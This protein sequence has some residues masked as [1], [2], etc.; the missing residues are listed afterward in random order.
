MH[1]YNYAME[2][3][4]VRRPTV[5]EPGLAITFKG[6]NTINKFWDWIFFRFIPLL[7]KGD[8]KSNDILSVYQFRNETS[9]FHEL[10]S[11]IPNRTLLHG[12]VLL[13]PPRLRQVRVQKDHCE[14][15]PIFSKYMA[16]CYASY[17]WFSE[18]KS[19]YAGD[20]FVGLW[21]AG[22]MPVFGE[23][24]TYLGAGYIK[25][26]SYDNDENI[27]MAES[28]KYID[29]IDRGTRMVMLEFNM[30]HVNTYLFQSTRL[31]VEQ[32]P[33]GGLVPSYQLHTMRRDTFFGDS[34]QNV[35]IVFSFYF[36]VAIFTARD[37]L[38]VVRIGF[39]K[40]IGQ[41]DNLADFVCYLGCYIMLFINVVQVYYFRGILIAARSCDTFVNL[42]VV[43][44]ISIMYNNIVGLVIFLVWIR[45]LA[46]FVFNRTMVIFVKV[47][48][49][50]TYEM[51]G[52]LLMFFAIIVAYAQCGMA[53]FEGHDKQF[54]DLTTSMLTMVRMLM[55]DFSYED[56]FNMNHFV[57][58]IYYLSFVVVVYAMLVFA[59][60]AIVNSTYDEVRSFAQTRPT[61]LGLV[62][63]LFFRSVYDRLYRL[64]RRKR[65]ERVEYDQDV[66]GELEFD[67]RIG[68]QMAAEKD[69]LR[70]RAL[71]HP[72]T[73]SQAEYL[74]DRME[75]AGKCITSLE[76]VTGPVLKRLLKYL[77]IL[78]REQ[79]LDEI[80]IDVVIPES[81]V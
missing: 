33:T 40:Y 20:R 47:V 11:C 2:R 15:N 31:F 63:G 24:K 32:P 65:K 80:D 62:I 16:S 28:I 12:N 69:V 29:W 58:R 5:M 56:L 44:F 42:D 43:S 34:W 4:L 54:R 70:R 81:N 67:Q 9:E 1:Y 39:C 26:F 25:S 76:E 77:N 71:Q 37:I 59:M 41:I 13:G 60:L 14:Y 36:M 53:F 55:C 46:F 57:T 10:D 79:G 51:G 78:R 74:P 72:V 75:R 35:I 68:P 64:V 27:E 61:K 49:E 3:Q 52:F 8:F 45:M 18:H 66:K 17:D 23:I 22:A 48:K 73:L 6:I 19:G 7:N 30:Y 21:E 38:I 50:V